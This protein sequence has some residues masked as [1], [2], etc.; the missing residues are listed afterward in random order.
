MSI[1]GKLYVHVVLDRSGSMLANKGATIAAYNNYIDSLGDD[2]VVSLT[3]FA[4]S[5]DHPI[6]FA[7]PSRA[8]LSPEDYECRG[9]TLLRDTIGSVVQSI[10]SAAKEYDRVALVVQ[11]DGQ[12]TDSREFTQAQIK[13]LLTDKQEGEGWLVIFLGAT[14]DAFNQATNL[15]FVAGNSMQYVGANTAQA[16]A[17]VSRSTAS[18]SSAPTAKV[19][20][21]S[22]SFTDEE[23]LKSK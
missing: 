6:M 21:L 1:K 7:K 13:Q 20:R 8:K 18:Y 22:A 2:A 10:D 16:M 19:G 9:G 3:T 14:L 23:R 5:A 12:D 11:T 15:G 4:G 17:S